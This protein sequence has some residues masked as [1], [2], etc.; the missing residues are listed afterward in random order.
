MGSQPVWA[1]PA[2][3]T[4][5]AWD[6]VT[7]QQVD[8]LPIPGVNDGGPTTLIRWGTD[9]LAFTISGWYQNQ[10]YLV[11]SSLV[12][13]APATLSG[14]LK[15]TTGPFQL[16]FAG[17]QGIPYR[18]WALTNLLNWTA[19]GV[20]NL[21]SNGEFWFRDTNALH[22]SERFYRAAIAQ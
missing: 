16:N 11:R 12:P 21:V 9:G 2:A 14:G 18:I 19:L 20:P 4:V 5:Y 7:L 17:Y 3:W 22:Y 10:I 1:S 13:I 15:Q 6:P 8:N